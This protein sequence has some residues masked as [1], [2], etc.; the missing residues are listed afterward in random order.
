M[1]LGAALAP[2]ITARLLGSLSWQWIFA[3]YAIPGLVWAL[4]F[5]SFVPRFEA[6][7][8]R[9]PQLPS[10]DDPDWHALPPP[11]ASE[12]PTTGEPKAI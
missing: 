6:P 5:A 4:T 12:S 9:S 3:L 7:K 8:V 1:S 2:A 11:S 10:N